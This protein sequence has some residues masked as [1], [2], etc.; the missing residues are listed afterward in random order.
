MAQN[1]VKSI[2]SDRPTKQPKTGL[3]QLPEVKRT[4]RQPKKFEAVKEK[5]KSERAGHLSIGV[6][7]YRKPK[8]EQNGS[9]LK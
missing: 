9:K 5:R 2:R 6:S 8:Q 1:I 7:P 3:D 4:D